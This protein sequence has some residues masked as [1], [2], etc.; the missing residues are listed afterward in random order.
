MALTGSLA[1]FPLEGILRLLE[2]THK[3][4]VLQI[5]GDGE[6]GTLEVMEGRLCAARY[7]EDTGREALGVIF[8]MVEASFSFHPSDVGPANLSG[9]LDAL[10]ERGAGEKD[11]IRAIRQDIP[12]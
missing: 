9:G 12:N 5:V 11:R 8:A 6:V 1:D 10:L 2:S 3:T 7:G 4:G